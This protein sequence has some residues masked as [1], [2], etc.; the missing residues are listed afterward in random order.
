MW[1]RRINNKEL[2]RCKSTT[3]LYFV[4][5]ARQRSIHRHTGIHS[6]GSKNIRWQTHFW[7]KYLTCFERIFVLTLTFLCGVCNR[8]FYY[9]KPLNTLFQWKD[10][11]FSL[12]TAQIADRRTLLLCCY[13][14]LFTYICISSDVI[15]LALTNLWNI[16]SFI[17]VVSFYVVCRFF[18][19]QPLLIHCFDNVYRHN[20]YEYVIVWTQYSN[21]SKLKIDISRWQWIHF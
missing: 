7:E 6:T 2:E 13:H 19:K 17:A 3:C 8:F 12:W 11:I 20:L 14:T 5:S 18:F 21:V 15:K 16:F 9:W 4:N 10:R 1:R